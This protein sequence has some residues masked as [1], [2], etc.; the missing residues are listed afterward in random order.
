M[1]HSSFQGVPEYNILTS[2]VKSNCDVFTY[3]LPG[4]GKSTI[5]NEVLKGQGI[6]FVKI[7]CI[8]IDSKSTLLKTLS[9]K[10]KNDFAYGIKECS[11]MHALVSELGAMKE[12]SERI[13]EDFQTNQ[14][15]V[16]LDNFEKLTNISEKFLSS[17]LRIKDSVNIHFSFIFICSSIH[18][19]MEEILLQKEFSLIPKVNI[20][21]PSMTLLKSILL[22][23]V[24]KNNIFD[25]NS[26]DSKA[27]DTFVTDFVYSFNSVVIR[28]NHYKTLIIWI[29][30]IMREYN[31]DI[32]FAKITSDGLYKFSKRY[33]INNPFERLDV[34]EILTA[35]E[36][37]FLNSYVFDLENAPK[38][39]ELE[40][41]KTQSIALVAC[42]LGNRNPEKTDKRIFKDYKKRSKVKKS[43]K[44]EEEKKL[45]PLKF[46]RFL[47]LMQALMSITLEDCRE[48]QMFHH[49]ME[50]YAEVNALVEMGYITK[51]FT[52]NNAF[53]KMRYVCNLDAESIK[54]LC[55]NLKIRFSDFLY[56]D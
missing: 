1:S 47:A 22:D 10:L 54:S 6:N 50:F 49:S 44:K 26:Q 13:Q 18:D 4:I 15:Y 35:Y 41:S 34:K 48:T 55:V 56:E 19:R 43:T 2:L 53:S 37:S 33:L 12:V 32:A 39:Q 28:I 23:F 31:Q 46:N 8:G 30:T 27:I 25:A 29:W 17:M 21:R 36:K 3:G 5:V 20:K 42:Y 52:Q 7:N 45:K 14:M 51:M 11:T 16:V 40:V 24:V 9:S 38:K